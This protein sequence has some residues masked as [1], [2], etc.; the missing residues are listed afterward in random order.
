MNVL[1]VFH[2]N[3]LYYSMVLITGITCVDGPVWVEQRNFT[4][5]HLRNSGY[6][7]K[8]MEALIN[9]ELDDIIQLLEKERPDVDFESVF[10]PSVLNI[11]WTLSTGIRIHR[12][13]ERLQRLVSMLNERSKAFDIAG[14]TLNQLPW[15]R[16]IIPEKIGYNLL[17]KLNKEMKE[18]FTET[19]MHHYD[20]WQP[21]RQDDLI[22]SFITE[23]KQNEENQKTFTG[24]L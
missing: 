20:T 22:Y 9:E 17:L 23:M 1:Y 2:G 6:G 21:G 7:K 15:L 4:V 18:F 24:K 8:T 14:G 11:L 19:I 13:D 10:P 3:Y 12:D 5:R 16:F